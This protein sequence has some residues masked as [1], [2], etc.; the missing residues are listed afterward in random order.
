MDRFRGLRCALPSHWR[1]PTTAKHA[2]TE[3]ATGQQHSESAKGRGSGVR[4]APHTW[5]GGG[6]AWLPAS[7]AGSP[8][9]K[10]ATCALV[11]MR[12]LDRLTPQSQVDRGPCSHVREPSIQ[13]L[14]LQSR[15][16]TL[17]WLEDEPQCRMPVN[18]TQ[19]LGQATALWQDSQKPQ[20]SLENSHTTA[21]T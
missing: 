13:H 3:G 15:A 14:H 12:R 9:T 1:P 21:Q 16:T 17:R 7:P 20:S 6:R 4:S 11:E 10:F 5:G 2:W 8:E 18:T 19:P